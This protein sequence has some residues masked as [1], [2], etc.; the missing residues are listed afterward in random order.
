[1]ISAIRGEPYTPPMGLAYLASSLEQAGH[2]VRIVDSVNMNYSHKEI[3]REIKNFEPDVVGSDSFTAS[4]YE[5]LK[6]L[7]NVKESLSNCI[8]VLGGYHSTALAKEI[9]MQHPYVD[10][11]VKGEG[12]K[13]F[14]E[15]L[16][17]KKVKQYSAVK[18]IAYRYNNRIVENEPRERIKDLDS[19]PFPAYHL[20]PMKKKSGTHNR[21]NIQ[22]DVK[23]VGTIGRILTSRGCPH[24]CAFC[25]S[26]CMWGG[27]I[28]LRKAEKIVEEIKLLTDKYNIKLIK[29]SD[30]TFAID[31]KRTEKIS[32]L[33][34]KEKI[35]V[36]FGCNTRTN[37]FDKYT[38]SLLKKM[39]CNLVFF[40]FESG[41]QKTL[42]FLNKNISINDSINA[43]KK[44][45]DEGLNIMGNFIIG[46][47]GET[48]ENINHTI[49]FAKKL[50]INLTTFTILTPYPGTK[51][52]EY[53]VKNNL[54]LTTDWSKYYATN[55]VMR[56]PGISPF[57]L[58]LFLLKGYFVTRQKSNVF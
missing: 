56:I 9:L 3:Y 24:N 21:F 47:P 18:G 32:N 48:K 53:A 40:G 58:K 6:I 7:K 27:K 28:Y 19:I 15:L 12:E 37:L 54:L 44:A 14:V 22:R 30:E 26:H 2:K 29:I 25:S 5:S 16:E 17:K 42:N 13:T 8:T 49:F 50:D 10:I 57:E 45:K 36:S 39:G 4:I 46:V 1:M 33:L 11:I 38:A 20:L 35:D 43:V 31:K 55:S 52:Y 41:V 23:H 34:K 51:I